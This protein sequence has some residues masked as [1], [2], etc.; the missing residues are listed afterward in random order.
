MAQ[1]MIEREKFLGQPIDQL[2]LADRWK[3]TGSWVALEIYSP[4]RLPLRTIEAIGPTATACMKQLLAQGR[5]P[6]QFEYEPILQPYD[7]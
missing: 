7:A 1:R 3:L 2:T 6:A 5:D 4:Q